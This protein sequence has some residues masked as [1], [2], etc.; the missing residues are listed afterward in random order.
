MSSTKPA[1][2]SGVQPSGELHIGN[3]LG[4]LKN[5]IELQKNYQCYFFIADLHSL[6]ETFTPKEKTKQIFDLAVD[7]LAIGLDPKKS[8]LFIQSHIPTHL[9]LSW[10]LSCFTPYAELKRMTQFKDKSEH[11]PLNINLGLFG[12]PVLQA[13]DI[14]IYKPH[15][16]PVGKDQL[17]HL[18]ITRMLA[19]TFNKKFGRIFPEPK[20]LLTKAFNI[21]GLNNPDKKMSKSYG[22]K[23]YIALQD[24]PNVIQEKLARAVTDSG[25]VKTSEMSPGV[26]NLF[27]L[28]EHFSAPE[29][30]KKFSKAYQNNTLKYQEL[31]RKLSI[32][33]ANYFKPYREE[34]KRLLKNPKKVM[35]I[36][37]DG[38]EKA[39]NVAG[40]TMTEVKQV[41]GLM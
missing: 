16:V 6:T 38:A 1:I 3:Y 21:M 10:I 27:L 19:R 2:V 36:F 30:F 29:A 40:K 32:D 39:R 31:K 9:E 20:P 13:A 5:F 17:Q 26:A 8:V 25:P 18:E 24:E 14:L 23:N 33:I 37:E 4:A 41:I 15:A 34:K 12:Y 35:K 7:F 11:D 22:H 28:L